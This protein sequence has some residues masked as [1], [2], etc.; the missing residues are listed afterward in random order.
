MST[1]EMASKIRELKELQAMK[2]EL[3]AEIAALQDTIK[4]EMT[5]RN[6]NEMVVDVFKVRWMPVVSSRFDTTTFKKTHADL[7]GQYCK[8]VETRR[9]TVA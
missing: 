8:Q 9:F 6:V 7:Y 1:N 5:A 3:D 2:D 4:A